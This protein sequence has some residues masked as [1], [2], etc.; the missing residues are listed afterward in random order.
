MT[1]EEIH[2]AFFDAQR[3]RRVFEPSHAKCQNF[4]RE[5]VPVPSRREGDTRLFEFDN[6]GD[7]V[8]EMVAELHVVHVGALTD[9]FLAGDALV[10]EASLAVSGRVVDRYAPSFAAAYDAFF[11]TADAKLAHRRATS[12]AR[13]FSETEDVSEVLYVPLLFACCRHADRSLPIVA[14]GRESVVVRLELGTVPGLRVTDVRLLADAVYL[15]PGTRATFVDRPLLYQLECVQTNVFDAPP[16]VR[17]FDARLGFVGPVKTLFFVIER[18]RA[19]REA[20]PLPMLEAASLSIG[21]IPRFERM[22]AKWWTGVA[23]RGFAGV[24]AVDADVYVMDFCVHPMD[25]LPSGA[26]VFSGLPDVNLRLE[27]ARDTP[28]GCEVH[29]VALGY[30]YLGVKAGAATLLFGEVSA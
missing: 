19:D 6:S 23:R 1:P 5:H 29:V 20:H 4:A 28:Q 10:A 26:T 16:G 25:A 8:G 3:G 13:F 30:N 12:C 24:P 15:D 17:V 2:R 18:T 27:L 14:L 7:L 22:G 11:R 21:G 9:P